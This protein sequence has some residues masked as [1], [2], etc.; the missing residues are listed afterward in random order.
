MCPHCG[1][2]AGSNYHEDYVMCQDCKKI[3]IIDEWDDSHF[4]LDY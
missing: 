3:T 1:S 4:E 2:E